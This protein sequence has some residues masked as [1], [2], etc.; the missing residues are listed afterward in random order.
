[1]PDLNEKQL[2]IKTY[3]SDFDNADYIKLKKEVKDME[4]TAENVIDWLIKAKCN[5]TAV[6]ICMR[7][8]VE[9]TSYLA[10]KIIFPIVLRK[11]ATFERLIRG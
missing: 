4:K 8:V 5:I 10:Q 1:M 2:N 3:R 6:P 9:Y 7:K 11:R